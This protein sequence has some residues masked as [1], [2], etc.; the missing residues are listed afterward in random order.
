MY[1]PFLFSFLKKKT[2]RLNLTFFLILK[3]NA[4]KQT[5]QKQGFAGTNKPGS[6]QQKNLDK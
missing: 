6:K 2:I 4:R 5:F 3:K 1:L